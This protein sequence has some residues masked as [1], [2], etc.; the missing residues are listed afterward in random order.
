MLLQDSISYGADNIPKTLLFVLAGTWVSYQSVKLGYNMFF[1]PLSHIPGPKLA[2][3]T[4]FPEFYYDVVRSGCYTKRI[5]QMHEQ[6]GIQ[7][8]TFLPKLH[9]HADE[10]A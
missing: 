4:Y 1:H 6:Y 7:F 3:A 8:F 9:W 2:A 5:R 10:F